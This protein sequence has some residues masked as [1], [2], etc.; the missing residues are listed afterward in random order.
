MAPWRAR[1]I[2]HLI[3]PIYM[4]TLAITNMVF[5]IVLLGTYEELS[6]RDVFDPVIIIILVVNLFFFFDMMA[7]FIV[8]R[9]VNVWNNKKFLYIELIFQFGQ[10]AIFF[11]YMCDRTFAYKDLVF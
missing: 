9:P 5:S 4:G 1:Y 3:N 2:K 10:I 6:F 8:L 11:I 7:N